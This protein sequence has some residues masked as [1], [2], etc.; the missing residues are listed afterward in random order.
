M[1]VLDIAKE[2]FKVV[3]MLCRDL[4]LFA[5]EWRVFD[6]NA[7]VF[8]PVFGLEIDISIHHLVNNRM[9]MT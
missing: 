5:L 1:A 9:P 6:I 2:S 3:L 7:A 4:M 8:A